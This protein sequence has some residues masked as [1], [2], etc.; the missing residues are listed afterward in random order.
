M[1]RFGY[2]IAALAAPG[3]T[4]ARRASPAPSADASAFVA[5][6]IA[7]ASTFANPIDI[8]YRFALDT[9][10][11]RDIADPVIARFN[12]EYY[13]F[14]SKSGGYWHSHDLRAWALVAPEG[15]PL[16]GDAPAVFALDGTLY[17]S[18]SESMALY[19]SEDP[20][21]GKWRKVASLARYARPAAFA[22]DGGPVYLYYRSPLD[23]MIAVVALDPH[24][25]FSAVDA[26]RRLMRAPEG[27]QRIAIAKHD[28]SYYLEVTATTAPHRTALT[29]FTSRSPTGTFTELS[30]NQLATSVGFIGGVGSSSTFRD[31]TGNEWRVATLTIADDPV[32]ERRLGIF[33]AGFDSSGVPRTNTWLGDYPQLVPGATADPLA[34]NLTGWMLLSTGKTATASSSLSGHP[35]ALAFDDDAATW[36]SAASGGVGEWL[37]VDLG[38][39]ARLRALQINFAEQGTHAA[40]RDEDSYQQYI[41]ESS[42]DGAHWTT[43][44][45]ASTSTHDAPHRYVQLD[46]ARNARFV[47]ITNVHAA[48]GGTFAIRDLRIFGTSAVAAPPVVNTFSVTRSA[49]DTSAAVRW[50]RVPRATAYVVRYGVAPGQLYSSVEVGDTTSATVPLDSVRISAPLWFTVDAVGEGGVAR[51]KTKKKG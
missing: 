23:S 26:P 24:H 3:C 8:D 29:V 10:S 30:R 39:I 9:L 4:G 41:V 17:Y 34:H 28:S 13:L 1:R 20:G 46:S 14:A 49:G 38:S 44:I 19:A 5:G 7:A 21:A 36:W 51:G 11:R 50:S 2:V 16:D 27:L 12:D 25:G 22:A 43:R 33:P 31:R 37:S 18:A 47:R 40:G 45:D 35:T 15:G 42:I 6:P 32:P 48:A